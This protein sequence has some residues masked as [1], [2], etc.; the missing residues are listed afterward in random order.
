MAEKF[1]LQEEEKVEKYY[2]HNSYTQNRPLNVAFCSYG[3]LIQKNARINSTI[4]A[5]S[6]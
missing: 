6:I 3:I 4:W 5:R 1:Y 2:L